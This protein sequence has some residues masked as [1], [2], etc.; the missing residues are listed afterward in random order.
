M[1]YAN[2][3]NQQSVFINSGQSI[4]D[5][6]HVGNARSISILV[7]TVSSCT[8]YIQGAPTDT[9]SFFRIY[10]AN[11]LNAY[12]VGSGEK[13]LAL[14]SVYAAIPHMKVELSVTQVSTCEFIVMP[15]I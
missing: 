9:S 8:M 5:H 3:R 4:S 7:P 10:E 11:T 12:N 2:E 13:I 1:A 15:F 14:S 6:F